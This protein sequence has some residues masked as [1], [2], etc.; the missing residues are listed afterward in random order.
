MRCESCNTI[1]TPY[2]D[3]I[4]GVN[5]GVRIGLCTRCLK[6][7]GIDYVGEPLA[8]HHNDLDSEEGYVSLSTSE[9]SDDS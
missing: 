5:T 6:E 1:L 7:T 2:E 4:L 3:S 8:Q 9:T